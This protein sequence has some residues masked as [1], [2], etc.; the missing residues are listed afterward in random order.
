MSMRYQAAILTASYFPLKVPNP[1]T[2]V[3]GTAGSSFAS[4]SFTAPTDVGGG[5]I[6]SYTVTSSPGGFTGTGATSPITVSGLTNGTSYT[7]TVTATNA[8]GTGAAS[9]ASS[10]VTPVQLNYVDDVF[11]TYLYDGNSSTQ[12]ITNNIDLSTNGGLVWIKSRNTASDN[13]LFDTARGASNGF[14]KSNATDTPYANPSSDLT[15]FGASGFS[16]N[17]TTGN[18]NV[19]TRTYTSW[20]FRKQPKFFDIVTYTG[21]GSSPRAISHSLDSVPG[22]VIIK[23][24]SGTQAWIVRHRSVGDT[25]NDMTNNVANDRLFLDTFGAAGSSSN[26][27]A[28]STTFTVGH[29]GDLNANGSTYVAY[30]FAH[31]AGGFGA[32]GNDNVISCG[33][34]NGNGSTTGPVVTLGWEPQWLMIKKSAGGDISQGS[35][36]WIIF[37]NLRGFT[38]SDRNDNYLNPNLFV[39]EN[40]LG[41]S[42]FLRPLATGFQPTSGAN[43]TNQSG[44]SYIYIAVRRPNKP[45]TVGTSVFN[46]VARSGTGAVAT[47]TSAGFPVDMTWIKDRT[48]AYGNQ[49]YDRLREARKRLGT[50]GTFEEQTDNGL[51]SFASMNGF[52]LGDDATNIGVNRG[53]DNFI[54]WCFKR[55]PSFFDIVCYSGNDAFNRAIPHNLAVVPELVIVKNRVYSPSNWAVYS[56]ATG[57]GNPMAL[58]SAD[59]AGANP[60]VWGSTSPTSTNF[61]VGDDTRTNGLGSGFTYVMYLFATCAGV[62]KV[63][64]YTGTGASQTINCGFTTGARFVMIKCTTASANWVV[65]D[66]ARGINDG[67][68]DPSLF[69]NLS[70]AESTGTNWITPHS[71]GFTLPTGFGTTNNSGDTY[72]F[73]A[74]A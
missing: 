41:T 27:K 7:F 22:C 31:N 32:S 38:D 70:D 26:I 74:I 64:S 61:Y 66:T 73:L 56:T 58:N 15:S 39:V 51:T 53:G 10:A 65:F 5:A 59:A 34:Y 23:L 8:F 25:P 47:V 46:S 50:Y 30:I 40:D 60:Y 6:T 29:T 14:L 4:I 18:V 52:T 20:T 45:P 63:G 54:N 3:V 44:S 67:S 13:A 1:P 28:D 48:S 19:S 24:T 17:N 49:V 11:S 2:S 35:S 72:I 36:S 71:T 42:N 9:A 55:A 62:S 21:N 57:L 43:L 69:L 33:S 12:T 16:L 37:D 68:A